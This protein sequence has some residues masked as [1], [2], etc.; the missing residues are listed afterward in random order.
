VQAGARVDATEAAWNQTPLIFAAARGHAAAVRALV[1]AGA[2]PNHH[3]RW[4]DVEER[5]EADEA[6]DERLEEVLEKLKE[7]E[8]GG[9]DWRPT[10]S[11]VQA[12]IEA[13]REVQR[14]WPDVPRPDQ[15]AEEG[16][17]AEESASPPEGPHPRKEGAAPQVGDSV[18]D[19]S[20]PEE[21]A[22]AAGDDALTPPSPD[23]AAPRPKSYAQMVE[24]WGGL[25]PLLHAVRQGHREA[26]LDLIGVGADVNLASDGDGTTPLLMAALNG[27]FD[28]AI[29]LLELGADP[30]AR[31]VAGVTPLFATLERQW[32]P[33]A[34]YAHPTAHQQQES[35]HLALLE[36]LLEAGADPNTRL[37]SHLWFMEYT[38]GVLR[39]SGINLEGAT[40]FWRAA[41]ALDVDAMR[42]LKDHGADP[43]LATVKP[44][45][46]RRRPMEAE[47][48]EEESEEGEAQPADEDEAA[49]GEGAAEPTE[50]VGAE[51]EGG[52]IKANAE[53]ESAHEEEEGAAEEE[54]IDH[55]GVP[56]VEVGG[57]HIHPL[58]AASGV[59]YGQSFAGN[60]H[61]YV[62]G[63]WLA[64]VRFLVEECG[65][66][67]NLRDAN[68]Y[69]PLH[70]AASRGDNELIR[71]LVSQGADVTLVSRSGQ[72]TADMANGPV[73]RVPPYPET[74]DLL[75]ELGA[76]NNDKCVSC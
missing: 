59:G 53:G 47:P 10:P 23:S 45:E 44:P 22:P 69:T 31:G 49:E 16:G 55:S 57:P 46:R 39:G 67:V 26:A 20:G 75:V 9:P 7:S 21:G 74:I 14:R 35:T 34:S 58:H 25:T 3:T 68:A 27:Q 50:A 38:F 24:R 15:E 4:V 2:D 60:A 29:E 5:S 12:A 17:S 76:K 18:P 33:R 56:P 62:P 72:T 11:Q 63:N 13:A 19:E 1:K 70:H 36:A 48:T 71:Y 73:Q 37:D 52:L 66:D 6:A 54:E 65:A 61:R 30:N 41:Y 51:E 43:S 32:A 28:L 64:A 40:P 42:L 8:G